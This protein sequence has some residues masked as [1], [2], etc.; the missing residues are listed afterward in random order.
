MG[1]M[2]P[3]QNQGQAKQVTETR[4]SKEAF[5]TSATWPGGAKFGATAQEVDQWHCQ[6]GP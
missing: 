2:C 5:L 1:I 6:T 3:K 4:G